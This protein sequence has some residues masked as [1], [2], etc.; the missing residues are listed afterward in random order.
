MSSFT[1]V[2]SDVE[3]A[4]ARTS[5]LADDVIGRIHAAIDAKARDIRDSAE[6]SA[7]HAPET[8]RRGGLAS[9]LVKA[10]LISF[11]TKSVLLLLLTR[12][13]FLSLR[14]GLLAAIVVTG[15]CAYARLRRR[16]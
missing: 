5:D 7:E 6:I 3:I 8:R 2:H 10:F 9:F 1:F 11:A 13:P 4:K 16:S 15:V 12:N 14:L